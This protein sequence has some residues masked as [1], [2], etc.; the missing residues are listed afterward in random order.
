MVDNIKV[1][2]KETG[3]HDV[4]WIHVAADINTWRAL[5]NMVIIS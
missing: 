1:K 3:K 2:L 4:D 5:V